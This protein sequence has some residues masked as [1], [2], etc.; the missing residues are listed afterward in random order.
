MS[1][2]KKSLS[3]D[4][5]AKIKTE[6]LRLIQILAYEKGLGHLLK[7]ASNY[8][9]AEEANPYINVK[10]YVHPGEDV[11]AS[12]IYQHLNK[13]RP[14]GIISIERG[15]AA[16]MVRPTYRYQEQKTGAVY[17]IDWL[18]I[19]L[20]LDKI[21]DE[22][23]YKRIKSDIKQLQR[24][25][26]KIEELEEMVKISDKKEEDSLPEAKDSPPAEAEGSFSWLSQMSR[27]LQGFLEPA[28]K[29]E[30]DDGDEDIEAPTIAS[31]G[32][33]GIN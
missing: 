14:A 7:G 24:A 8:V 17:E 3:E 6:L 12:R 25:A 27:R 15:A 29:S 18:Q 5:R 10:P 2:D 20:D 4:K 33:G 11:Y 19:R 30:T 26:S 1:E 32:P 23:M 22:H 31:G 21:V 13:L 28:K 16:K 9:T